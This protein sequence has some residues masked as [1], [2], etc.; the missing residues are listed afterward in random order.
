MTED[1]AQKILQNLTDEDR[2]QIM[3]D[4]IDSDPYK[5]NAHLPA[6]PIHEISAAEE[7]AD[8]NDDEFEE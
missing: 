4:L 5:I 6:F 7:Q 1:E 8:I 2:T 3:S